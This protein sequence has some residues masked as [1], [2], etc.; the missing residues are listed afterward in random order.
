[1]QSGPRIR[2]YEGKL[3]VTFM[4]HDETDFQSVFMSCSFDNGETW[5]EEVEIS[6]QLHRNVYPDVE[7]DSNGD[8]HLI[9]YNFN[10]NWHFN[11]VFTL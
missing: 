10:Q 11:G 9:Y 4:M 2:A 6:H 7:I 5:N 8:I 3:Y 1:M